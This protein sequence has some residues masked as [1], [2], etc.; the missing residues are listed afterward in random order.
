M[1]GP[2]GYIGSRRETEDAIEQARRGVEGLEGRELDLVLAEVDRLRALDVLGCY[3]CLKPARTV[4]WGFA[5]CGN[6]THAEQARAH[7]RDLPPELHPM[8][9]TGAR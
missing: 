3:F 5:V 6:G 7:A 9:T 2:E 4:G 8:P 1:T